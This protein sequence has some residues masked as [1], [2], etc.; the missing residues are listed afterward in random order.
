MDKSLYIAMTGASATLR[1]QASVAHN[2]AN[3]DTTGFQAN[4]QMIQAQDQL[5][6]TVINIR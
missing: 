1:G 6:Q 3:V 4:A 5:T 2:L